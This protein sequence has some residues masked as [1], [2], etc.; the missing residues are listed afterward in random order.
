[1]RRGA[2]AAAVEARDERW[3]RQAAG[4]QPVTGPVPEP[5]A[6]CW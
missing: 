4:G 1:M 2:D 5:A 3:R 6:G